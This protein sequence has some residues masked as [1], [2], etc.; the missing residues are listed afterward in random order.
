MT[1]I[2]LTAAQAMVRYLAAQ[3]NIN[4]ES[5]VA[6]CWAIFGHGNVVGMGE[7]LHGVRDVL[8]TYRG[9][10]EQTMAHTA[11]AYAKQLKRTR[12]MAVT[13]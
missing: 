2:R 12:L 6:G 9:Q 10:N 13:S 8:P 3:R 5:L 4:G 11:I 1:T 7:A